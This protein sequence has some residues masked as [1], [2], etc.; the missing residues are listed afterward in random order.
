MASSIDSPIPCLPKEVVLPVTELLSSHDLFHLACVSPKFRPIAKHILYKDVRL[1]LPWTGPYPMQQFLDALRRRPHLAHIVRRLNISIN[2]KYIEYVLGNSLVPSSQ[3][4]NRI[5]PHLPNLR[6]QVWAP[7]T[8]GTL[9]SLLSRLQTLIIALEEPIGMPMVKCLFGTGSS[10]ALQ[11]LSQA[12][13]G[14]TSGLLRTCS[15]L[16]FRY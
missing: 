10:P 5:S 7:N 8:A 14:I 11:N 2:D 9:L 13:G 16:P 3:G 1:P 12:S 6:C 15:L 4:L